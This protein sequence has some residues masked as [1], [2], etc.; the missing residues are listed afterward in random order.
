MTEHDGMCP[1]EKLSAVRI[2]QQK[3]ERR[4][5]EQMIFEVI[6]DPA[7]CYASYEMVIGRSD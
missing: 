4:M 2:L 1:T 7:P 3:V 6:N 5:N